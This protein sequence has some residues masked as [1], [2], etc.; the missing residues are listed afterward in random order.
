MNLSGNSSQTINPGIYSQI[1]VSGN[2]KLTL[3]PGIYVIAGGGFTVSGNASVTGSGV[4]IYNAGS[5]YNAVPPAPT[6]LAALSA[7]SR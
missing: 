1:T 6:V 7:A 4:M 3:N 5:T 2:A